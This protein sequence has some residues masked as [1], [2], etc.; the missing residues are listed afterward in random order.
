MKISKWRLF[1]KRGEQKLTNNSKRAFLYFVKSVIKVLI[2]LSG[3]G[4]ILK[5]FRIVRLD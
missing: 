1:K 2:A 3:C 4:E 5:S